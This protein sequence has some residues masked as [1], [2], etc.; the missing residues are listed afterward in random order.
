MQQYAAPLPLDRRN[1]PMQEYPAAASAL[2]RYGTENIAASSVVTLTD[3]TTVL[4]ITAGGGNIAMRWVA[5]TDT[6]ASV[7]TQGSGANFD[8]VIGSGVTRRFVVPIERQGVPSI[9]GLNVQNGLYKRVA[10]KAATAIGSVYGSE[11]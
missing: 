9:V 4:E 3:N 1:V 2:A 6:Q 11:F 8:H 7:V 10:W 5:S